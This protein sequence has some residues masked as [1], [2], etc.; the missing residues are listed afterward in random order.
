MSI[1][2]RK[3][4]MK[5]FTSWTFWSCVR[6][7]I[8]FWREE[9]IPRL[10][11]STHVFSGFEVHSSSMRPSWKEKA[12]GDFS[13]LVLNSPFLSASI[14][15]DG[16]LGSDSSSLTLP[17]LNEIAQFSKAKKLIIVKLN[18]DTIEIILLLIYKTQTCI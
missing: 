14:F 9:R 12:S 13:R 4:Q 3:Y 2:I 6:S 16:A 7:F 17:S 15:V 5:N 11:F 10:M 1:N 8:E 18:R